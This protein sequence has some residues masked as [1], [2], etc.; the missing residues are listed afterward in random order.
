M[1]N[2]SFKNLYLSFFHIPSQN[3]MS[4]G[5][6]TSQKPENRKFAPPA[7]SLRTGARL[8]LILIYNLIIRYNTFYYT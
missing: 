3:I 7:S 8:Q 4:I 6:Q 1:A 2:P 5:T